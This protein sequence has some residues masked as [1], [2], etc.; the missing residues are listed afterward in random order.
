MRFEDLGT[1]LP[2]H[3]LFAGRWK[4]C[5]TAGYALDKDSAPGYIRP[6]Q[7]VPLGTANP[8]MSV[9]LIALVPAG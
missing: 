7:P 2:R 5:T 6:F 9:R 4:H 3:N 1:F 8:R